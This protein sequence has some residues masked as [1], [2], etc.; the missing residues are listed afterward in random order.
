MFIKV[1]RKNCLWYQCPSVTPINF[2]F[3]SVQVTQAQAR[4]D[5]VRW[6]QWLLEKNFRIIAAFAFKSQSPQTLW[7]CM[8]LHSSLLSRMETCYLLGTASAY[9]QC[10]AHLHKAVQIWLAKA[11]SCTRLPGFW[12]ELYEDRIY[13]ITKAWGAPSSPVLP[14][15]HVS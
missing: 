12:G 4:W 8:S 9:K 11:S 3:T 14:Y 7:V 13:R 15:P 2:P 6:C 1:N 10:P 5:R